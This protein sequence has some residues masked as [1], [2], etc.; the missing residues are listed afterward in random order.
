MGRLP[1]QGLAYRRH[2]LAAW[3][4]PHR[5][6]LAC[7]LPLPEATGLMRKLNKALAPEK[8]SMKPDWRLGDL[9]ATFYRWVWTMQR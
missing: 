7:A 6:P 8:D 5:V 9:L 4:T 2:I 1:L 3:R